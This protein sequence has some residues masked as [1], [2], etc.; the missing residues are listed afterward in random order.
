MA[1][2]MSAVTPQGLKPFVF[3]RPFG[4]TQVVPFQITDSFRICG[5]AKAVPFQI[6]DSFR[7]CGVAKV[8]P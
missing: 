5:V 2:F 3:L 7:I 8:V 4:T 6:T 1:Q